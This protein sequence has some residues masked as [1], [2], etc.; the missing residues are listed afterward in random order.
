VKPLADSTAAGKPVLKGHMLHHE[1]EDFIMG[2]RRV[3]Q[4]SQ[5][6]EEAAPYDRLDESE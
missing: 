6:R 3:D 1:L 4:P 5:W 2:G